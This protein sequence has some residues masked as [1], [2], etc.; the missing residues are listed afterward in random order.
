MPPH[1]SFDRKAQSLQASS[2]VAAPLTSRPFAAPTPQEETLQP[3]ATGVRSNPLANISILNPD[4]TP[5]LPIQPKLTIGAVGDKYEQEADRVAHQVVQRINI[6]KSKAQPIQRQDDF[7]QKGTYDSGNLKG[8]E[9]LAHKLAHVVQQTNEATE[10]IQRKIFID[11]KE[12]EVDG[13]DSEEI[14][15][16]QRD[17]YG[18]WYENKREMQDHLLGKPTGVGLIKK[19]AL[20]YRIRE[21]AEGKFFV[22]GES[23]AGV[24]G[25]DI[26]EES[27]IE[28]PLLYEGT[29][30]WNA[31]SFNDNETGEEQGMEE[32]TA[33]LVEALSAP[34]LLSNIWM[35][36]MAAPKTTATEALPKGPFTNR[37]ET[38]GGTYK[39]V[40]GEVGQE[41]Y[42]TPQ[43]ELGVKDK[44]YNFSEEATRF[45]KSVIKE[46]FPNGMLDVRAI[47]ADEHEQKAYA[48]VMT[49]LK[50]PDGKD[51]S[52]ELPK[53]PRNRNKTREKIKGV[54][55]VFLKMLERKRDEDYAV[56]RKGR[57]KM[58]PDIADQPDA[59]AWRNEYML[60]SILRAKQSGKFAFA[61][62]GNRHRTAIESRLT[63]EGIPTIPV[64][65]LY[66]PPI[67]R[68]T[69][70]HD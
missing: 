59:D 46:V 12:Y 48:Y 51:L 60:A 57:E 43:E 31:A 69:D 25:P 42:W 2:R 63:D 50:Q 34:D 33:K 18:R 6:P 20:W 7:F 38:E 23:H 58:H 29:G 41:R 32:N 28:K 65:A 44:L 54:Q 5:Q 64:A 39:L 53:L 1:Q 68:N 17:E 27:H 4:T 37:R 3:Y 35:P 26:H 40:V 21:L 10:P 47:G 30:G 56:F 52:D 22:L 67:G 8:Q 16:A 66:Q 36:A 55:K 61:S 70:E 14:Q 49:V 13:Q 19:R 62:L 45:L 24:T 9:L 15:N 11:E